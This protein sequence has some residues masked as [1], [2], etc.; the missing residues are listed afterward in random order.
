MNLLNFEN[1]S[2]GYGEKN[3]FDNISFGID[4]KDKI[5]L[6]GINGTGKSTLLKIVAGLEEADEGKKTCANNIFI[7]YLAQIPEFDSS[8]NILQNVLYDKKSDSVVWENEGKA[9]SMLNRL[10]IKDFENGVENL[11]GGEKKRVAL[12]RTLISAKEV[13]VLDEPTNHLDSEMAAWLEDYLKNFKGALIMITHDRYFLDKV[14]NKIIELD[15][16]KIYTYEG[17]Y[18]EYI[19]LKAQREEMILATE[20]KA[21]SLYRT[22][23]EWMM[24][25][26][27]ARSTKQKAHIERFE[28][29]KN[30]EKPV[31]EKKL[32]MN[33][34]SSRMGKK[35]IE[36]NNI[37]KSFGDRCIIKDFT[38]IFLKNDRIGI[39]GN[40]GQGKSTLL[41]I[42]TG[43]LQPDEG[44]VE[45][46]QTVKIGYFSQENEY[47]DEKL[48]VIDYIK[49][50][51]EY[52][53]TVDGRISASQ[54]LEKFLFTPDKQYTVIEKLSGGERRRLY[55][56]KVLMEAPNVLILDEP[57][58]D[59]DVQTMT[60]LEDYISGFDGIVITV[61]HDRYFL[62]KVVNRIF[63]F[64]DGD[65]VQ[66]EGGYSDYRIA[67][68]KTHQK[69]ISLVYEDEKKDSSDSAS[70]N[71]WKKPDS[72]VKFS[73][74]EQREYEAIDGIIE[75]LENDIK[76]LEGD[77]IKFSTDFVK[78][79]ETMAK[80]AELEAQLEYQTERWIY[81]NELAE[82]IENNK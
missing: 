46:G 29:L 24:R 11:S 25:G 13:L 37:K 7:S 58:N 66:Y 27:R 32:E 14:T 64:E 75:K 22:E 42:I 48:K 4:E 82:Q 49:E 51:A 1:I 52:I 45:I 73:Y 2:K 15:K 72:K 68:D 55:L 39:I 47:M 28:N 9:K 33:S 12:A 21:K 70:K 77:I 44:T 17:G 62:D 56:L 23:L 19:R 53:L 60:I 31:E 26:A 67:F 41:K 36:L 71:T 57:T 6:I 80:K 5:G 79:N 10:G 63:A 35:T 16:G 20:R 54:M 3:L 30:R 50:T 78:L 59:L 40:N 65:I 76:S 34:V 43:Y 8:K 61:S 38:Y 81:L 18:S 69:D 74:N